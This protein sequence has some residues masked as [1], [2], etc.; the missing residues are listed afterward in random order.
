MKPFGLSG[1]LD[2]RLKV[3]LQ[4]KLIILPS[5]WPS[6][7]CGKSYRWTLLKWEMGRVGLGGLGGVGPLVTRGGLERSYFYVTGQG[8]KPR[9]RPGLAAL[10]SPTSDQSSPEVLPEHPAHLP[11]EQGPPVGL[12]PGHWGPECGWNDQFYLQSQVQFTR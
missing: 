8:S 1:E 4:L 2:L 10:G 5:P 9:P 12:S 3:K 6:V 7:A 11:L